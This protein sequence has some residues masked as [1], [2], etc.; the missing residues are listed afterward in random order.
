MRFPA[1]S[2]TYHYTVEVM[3]DSG[4]GAVVDLLSKAEFAAGL[5]THTSMFA[6]HSKV[7]VRL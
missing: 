4:T 1:R 3:C 6:Q 5:S 7:V 2:N